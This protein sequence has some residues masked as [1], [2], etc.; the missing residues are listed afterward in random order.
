MH[1]RGALQITLQRSVQRHPCVLERRVVNKPVHLSAHG[2]RG[3]KA[4]LNAWAVDVYAAAI[5]IAQLD[6]GGVNVKF[7]GCEFVHA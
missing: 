3:V 1:P 2:Q 6:T 5:G 7:A 4:V